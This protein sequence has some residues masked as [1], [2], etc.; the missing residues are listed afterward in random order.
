MGCVSNHD[1]PLLQSLHC[2]L[3]SVAKVLPSYLEVFIMDICDYF[4]QSSKRIK[5]LTLIQ[6]VTKTENHKITKLAQTHSLVITWEY[7]QSRIS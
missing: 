2:V 3:V 6:D 1:I 4:S 7:N 5:Y